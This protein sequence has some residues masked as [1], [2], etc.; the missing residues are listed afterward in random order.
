MFGIS[1]GKRNKKNKKN[2]LTEDPFISSSD[3]PHRFILD[4]T[5]TVQRGE[6]E[7]TVLRCYSEA[8][9][10][11]SECSQEDQV[12]TAPWRWKSWQSLWHHVS[13]F[14]NA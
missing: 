6:G 9:C 2:V 4:V 5:K 13:G 14:E 7:A 1:L 12:I 3:K 8:V 10:D 11:C